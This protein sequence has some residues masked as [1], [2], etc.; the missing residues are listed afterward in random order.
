MTVSQGA[1]REALRFK[2]ENLVLSKMPGKIS[3]LSREAAT[4]GDKPPTGTEPTWG[5]STSR[6][7]RAITRSEG[8]RGKEAFKPNEVASDPESDRGRTDLGGKE[9]IRRPASGSR[10]GNRRPESEGRRPDSQARRPNYDSGDFSWIRHDNS[11]ESRV[12]RRGMAKWTRDVTKASGCPGTIKLNRVE[13]MMAGT[14]RMAPSLKNCVVNKGEPKFPSTKVTCAHGVMLQAAVDYSQRYPGCVGVVSPASGYVCGGGF[15]TGGRHALEEALCVQTSVYESL[16]KAAQEAQKME[17][18]PARGQA[19]YIPLDGVV[20]S[21][22]VE[23]IRDGSDKG[24]PVFKEPICLAAIVSFAMPNCNP[25]LHN[26][27]VDVPRSQDEYEAWV[28]EKLRS[29]LVAAEESGCEILVMPDAGCGVYKNRAQTV[30]QLFASVLMKEFWGHFREIVLVG[31]QEFKRAVVDTTNRPATDSA[32][33]P[34]TIPA[35]TRLS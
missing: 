3:K 15:M 21:P 27:P 6:S 28:R 17:A 4:A 7:R 22:K 33:R 13:E 25:N 1:Y 23:V 31:T 14:R 18:S 9:D 10:A 26:T 24:Y 16:V 12:R 19:Q 30:G 32:N 29:V 5:V 11:E 35:R 2:F 8:A 20:I 34:S